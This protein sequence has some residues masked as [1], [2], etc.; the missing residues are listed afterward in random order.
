MTPIRDLLNRIRWDAEFARGEFVLG[1]FD[2]LEDRVVHVPFR[3][4]DFPP[5]DP[6]A[7]RLVDAEG[8]AHH[9]PLHRV[10]EVFKDGQRIWHRPDKVRKAKPFPGA[11]MAVAAILTTFTFWMI[12]AA[13]TSPSGKATD[14]VRLPDP[15]YDGSTSL[16]Q[17]LHRR[18][19][20]R[21]FSDRPL[22]LAEAGQL[23]WAAQGVTDT[24]G[25]RTA[26]SPERSI[27][28]RCSSSPAVSRE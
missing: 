11:A 19:S 27:R 15:R 6:Q 9:V 14:L 10:R 4:V 26:P 3:E 25:K 13:E 23:L 5:D 28:W 18:R 17:T 16:E 21:E 2:R 1:Y 24:E 22:T 7:F 12:M 20:V 8:R